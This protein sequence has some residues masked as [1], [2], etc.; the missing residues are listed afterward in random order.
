MKQPGRRLFYFYASYIYE[1]R[2]ASVTT[3]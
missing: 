3:K 1:A 2:V